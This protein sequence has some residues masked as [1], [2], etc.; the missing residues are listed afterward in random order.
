MVTLGDVTRGGVLAAAAEFDRVGRDEFLKSAEAGPD[1]VYFVQNDGK[2]YDLRAI[3]G[4]A[5][6]IST[7]VPLRPGGLRGQDNTAAQRL[8]GLGFKVLNLRR[9]AWTRH[10]IVLACALAEANGWRQVYDTDPRAKEL[11]Q[12]LQSPVIHPFPRHPDFRNAAGVGQKTR[13]IIDNHP[14]HRGSRSNG[15]RLDKEVLDR[16]LADPARMHAI[17]ARIREVLTNDAARNDELPD[18]DAPD[19]AA[20][21]SR[22]ERR[23]QVRSR[24]EAILGKALREA[25]PDY[26][27]PDGRLVAIYY[28]KI[29]DGGEAFLG[30]KNH[31]KDDDVLVLLLGDETNPKHLVFPRAEALLRYKDSFSP[32]GNSRL[33]PPIYVSD[34]SFVLRR[35]AK[36]LVISLDD[37]I[38]AYHELLNPM[39]RAEAE[40]TPIG[41]G[42]VEDDEDAVPRPAA[43]GVA[44]PDLVGRGNRAHKR[45]RNALAAHL[46][47]LGIEPLDPGPSDPPFDLAWWK[48]GVLYVAEVKSLTRANEHHQLRLGLGQLLYYCHLLNLRAEQVIPVLAPE[49]QPRDPEW[50]QLCKAL[51]VRLAFPPSFEALIDQTTRPRLP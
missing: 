8:E 13:N 41:R 33:V 3:V 7:G 26:V 21:G 19:A 42:F 28:S 6:D 11:S 32:V 35:P 10:E 5:H 34:G 22:A 2:F 48:G 46:R 4:Y 17:A 37:R 16:F 14:D 20:E 43:P 51:N 47:S 25:G 1:P 9:P 50:R 15:N 23:E 18:L 36:G 30:V 39:D 45:T 40:T 29:H 31:I 12:L 38:D 27:L 49:L 24:V 44:D